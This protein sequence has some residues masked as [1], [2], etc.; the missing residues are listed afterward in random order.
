MIAAVAAKMPVLERKQETSSRLTV[1][2]LCDL[3][4][5]NLGEMMVRQAKSD[6]VL[7]ACS[8]VFA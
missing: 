6:T 8:I 1:K 5:K 2:K 7:V 3:L 4:Q